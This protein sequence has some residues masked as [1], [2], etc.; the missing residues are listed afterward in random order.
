MRHRR[1]LVI[2][3]EEH[4]REITKLSLEAVAGW[5]VL[6]AA[7]GAEGLELAVRA[8][9]DAIL[10]DVR[11]PGIDGAATFAGLRSNT[12]TGAI[13][14][15]WLTA[16][17]QG[18]ERR[19]LQALGGAGCL[20][21]PFDPLTLAARVAELVGWESPPTRACVSVRNAEPV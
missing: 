18:D 19:R 20:A 13:P 2:E 16:S 17:V 11:M 7:S 8:V 21:K 9:P 14:V 10:L 5:E 12:L 4:I 3:D 6:T 15:I 1:V